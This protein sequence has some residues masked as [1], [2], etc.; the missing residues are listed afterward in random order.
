MAADVIAA[1]GRGADGALRSGALAE[2][3]AIAR[4]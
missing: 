3:E 4:A 2:I 1:R